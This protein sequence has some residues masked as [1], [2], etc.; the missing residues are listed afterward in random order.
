ML[1]VNTKQT[2]KK[3][4]ILEPFATL[5][6][7]SEVQIDHKVDELLQE[8]SPDK[9]WFDRKLAA[10]ELGQ[11][12]NP[13]AVPGLI[14]ALPTDPF[15]MVRCAII[16]ALETIGDPA[17]ILIL[18]EVAKSDDFSAVRSHAFRALDWLSRK[19]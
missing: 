1:A 18:E 2:Q 9:P 6:L 5:P 14:A 4:D 16:Q 17:A 10:I 11:M 13:E 15:W 3:V 19:M 12:Q 7:V 8:L